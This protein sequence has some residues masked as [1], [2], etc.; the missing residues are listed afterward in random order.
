M[1]GIMNKCLKCGRCCYLAKGLPCKYLD[2][3]TKLCRV[4]LT[5]LGKVTGFFKHQK[6]YCNK[7]ENVKVNYF[8]CPYNEKG[9]KF[10]D[11]GY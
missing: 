3:E 9:N 5:R 8:G 10:V 1:R 11:V 2:A 7:R 4:Y 6:Q